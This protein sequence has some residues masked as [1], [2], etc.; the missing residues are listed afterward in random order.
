MNELESAEATLGVLQTVLQTIT[1]DD[2]SRQTPCREF[3]VAALTDHLLNSITMIGGAAGAD[4]PQ[5]DLDA[6]VRDQVL[7]AARPAVAAWQQRGLDGTVPFG[8]GEVPAAMMARILS[9]E[10]L[11]HAWDYARAVGQSVEVPDARSEPVLQWAKGIITPDGRVRAGF[12]DPVDVPD[13]ASGLDRLL[14]FT[15]RRPTA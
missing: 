9:L 10:F 13:D 11:V 5:R 7:A 14:A 1:D 8:Q 4:I 3:D 6:P 15:G 12:D 2:L